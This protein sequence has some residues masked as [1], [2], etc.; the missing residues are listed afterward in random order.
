VHVNLVTTCGS[1]WGGDRD[2]RG[3]PHTRMRDGA[4]NGWGLLSVDGNR[5]ALR[6]KVARRPISYQMDIYCSDELQQRE[7]QGHEVLANIFNGS[8]KSEVW[9]RVGDTGMWSKMEQVER[10]DPQ[11]LRMMEREQK[12]R[13]RRIEAFGKL[14]EDASTEGQKTA[15]GKV[16]P[17]PVTEAAKKLLL[18]KIQKTRIDVP[19]RP[20]PKAVKSSHLW[21]GKLPALEPGTYLVHVKTRDMFGETWTGRRI[22][23]VVQDEI[24]EE[25]PAKRQDAN[26]D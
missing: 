2:E 23:R 20:L 10:E 5:F 8:K 18:D 21:A 14:V 19:W 13:E 12:F 4:P 3:V 1:W 6:T 11:Y 16:L 22:I 17:S 7:T 24:S 9:M 25:Q 15:S 26:K